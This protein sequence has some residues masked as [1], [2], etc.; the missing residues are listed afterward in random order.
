MN[1][2]GPGFLPSLVP[3]Q[4]MAVPG[5]AGSGYNRSSAAQLPG[6]QQPAS[7]GAG[8]NQ[9]FRQR[10]DDRSGNRFAGRRPGN[11]WQAD[12]EVELDEPNIDESLVVLDHFNSD[13]HL[14]I[15][16]DGYGGTVLNDPP[17][18]C[19]TWAGARASYGACKGKV[20]YEVHVVEHLPAD[21][22]DDHT[23]TDPHVVRLGWSLDSASFQLGE[24][25]WSYG[26]GGT[27]KFSTNNRFTDY[28]GRFQEGDVIGAMV[29]LDARPATISFMKNGT[30]LGVA[31]PLH[32][33]QVGSKEKALFPHVL[34]K[35]C[36]FKVNFGQMDAWYPPPKGFKY[37]GQLPLTE[38][39]RGMIAPATK[40][41]CEMIMIVGLPGSGKTTWGINMEKNHP[42]KRYN[43]IGTDTLIEK[44]RVMGLPRK[45]NY[46][47]RWDVLIDKATKCLN[48]LF[49][50]A[51]KR[52][53]NY[54]LDQ[55]NVY[56]T[57]RRR[58]M[59]NFQGFFRIAAVIQPDDPELERRSWQRTHVDG[60][61]V[62]ES[63]VLEMKANYS[64]PE[65][66]DN[67]FDRI[68]FVE[69]KREDVTRLIKIY[70]DE[71]KAKSG[72]SNSQNKF[73]S[74]KKPGQDQ[75][76]T[77]YGDYKPQNYGQSSFD[78]KNIAQR[79]R[80]HGF[81]DQN[82][83]AVKR[84]RPDSGAYDT[85]KRQYEEHDR[86]P[87]AQPPPAAG[88]WGEPA[89]IKEEP[90]FYPDSQWSSGGYSQD[91]ASY[92]PGLRGVPPAY[93]QSQ[94]GATPQGY[95]SQIDQDSSRQQ[96]WP[97]EQGDASTRSQGKDSGAAA[98]TWQPG[99]RGR[100]DGPGFAARDSGSRDLPYGQRETR[101]I[102]RGRDGDRD[103]DNDR[104]RNRVGDRDGY[105]DRNRERDRDR[106]WD[107][108][109]EY[110]RGNND[111]GGY[112]GND[113]TRQDV[114]YGGND[115]TRQDVGYGGGDRMRQD[116]GYGGA[117][118][119]RPDGGY[120]DHDRARPDGGYGGYDRARAD[121]GFG[122][123]DRVRPEGGFGGYDRARS[124]GGYGSN[125]RTRSDSG[126]SGNDRTRQDGAYSRDSAAPSWS[127]QSYGS[128]S[129][130]GR[131][132]EYSQWG[133][134]GQDQSAFPDQIKQEV[135]VDEFSSGQNAYGQPSESYGR[136][137]RFSA[138]NQP[139]RQRG[140]S[141]NSK[142][143]TDFPKALPSLMGNIKNEFEDSITPEVRKSGGSGL[144]N[145]SGIKPLIPALE[146]SESDRFRREGYASDRSQAR[147]P[148]VAE[149][150]SSQPKR[151]TSSSSSS[152]RAFP[153]D[154][155]EDK[156]ASGS[157]DK[158]SKP[159]ASSKERKSELTTV[160]TDGGSIEGPSIPAKD[161]PASDSFEAD[162]GPWNG[163]TQ[164][165]REASWQGDD[166]EP[167]RP[168]RGPPHYGS[169]GGPRGPA[170]GFRGPGPWN[171][172]HP[173]F[174]PQGPPRPYFSGPPG[175]WPRP[176][177]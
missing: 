176:P 72:N 6:V 43:I 173:R 34:S 56:A 99:W 125:D 149:N 18:F 166:M 74:N 100:E 48:K 112:G 98:G 27:G 144:L 79:K 19:F 127:N 116:V 115:R 153:P 76:Q 154:N 137:S 39:V 87:P 58:K 26:Y 101:D 151:S 64:I 121:G 89:P 85:P 140:S 52:R 145:Q 25:A 123:Y 7:R 65:E 103:R 21:F 84:S 165:P 118:R 57:A 143:D 168:P 159:F 70:N 77:P 122:G 36:R 105:G 177:R 86:Q 4:Y 120:G 157:D 88:R 131:Q 141:T 142:F 134:P 11:R 15:D 37:I 167:R 8:G 97:Q 28:G 124:D 102:G 94:F 161:G 128:G 150:D 78:D 136:P 32:G 96:I 54:I 17:G 95:E 38:R 117:D 172:N 41:D 73:D 22:G 23:E 67:L 63:A 59:R 139:A 5:A 30:W 2:Y 106:N 10:D 163:P 174:G 129:F 158:Q 20:Y 49:T 160:P 50:I 104:D 9:D 81:Y 3:Q 138:A 171:Q 60:K 45:R 75:K 152:R 69:L 40:S 33:L 12:T 130:T 110:N 175:R 148:P 16:P 68:D 24:E 82:E 135:D 155:S 113:R 61:F 35:N 51:A 14:V 66:R 126:Y 147:Q 164:R 62:P 53:R 93:G 47:G 31:T 119:T 114:G 156:F 29:D 92:K 132:E 109:S 162:R 55:T 133:P 91:S 42:E 46:H 169:F 71:G 83:S 90:G 111:R 44:M 108:G 170:G 80:E 107:R 1:R 13:L 146:G